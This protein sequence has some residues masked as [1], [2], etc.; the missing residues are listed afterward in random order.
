M[1]ADSVGMLG[2]RPASWGGKSS[3]AA[4]APRGQ[5]CFPLLLLWPMALLG[6]YFWV[7]VA[8]AVPCMNPWMWFLF[9]M[10]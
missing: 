6:C 4:L 2:W 7:I 9:I 8:L 3:V 1:E 5:F 10:R